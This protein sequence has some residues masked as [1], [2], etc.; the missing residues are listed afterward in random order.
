L[1]E[2]VNVYRV[3]NSPLMITMGEKIMKRHNYI[4]SFRRWVDKN[5]FDKL[6][7][8][9]KIFGVDL[10]KVIKMIE[11]SEK[12]S[13]PDGGCVIEGKAIKTLTEVELIR[14]PFI[15]TALEY[16]SNN[17]VDG[18]DELVECRP[19]ILL[20]TDFEGKIEMRGIWR[21]KNGY[22]AITPRIQ[23]SADGITKVAESGKDWSSDVIFL[24]DPE[25]PIYSPLICD[26][27]PTLE[28]D[29]LEIF[30][31]SM[32]RDL[33]EEWGVVFRLMAALSCSNVHIEKLPIPRIRERLKGAL[34]Y[35]SYNYL[36]IGNKNSNSESERNCR[37]SRSP[38]E[39]LR[40]GHIRRL[41]TGNKI[42]VNSTVVNP[43][44]GGKIIK[45]YVAC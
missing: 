28:S 10:G 11:L 37:F 42:W 3:T 40:R 33:E 38:R 12:F 9:Y 26:S 44:V 31:K 1:D 25:K 8:Y 17:E 4:R 7:G 15:A 24:S 19:R 27:K 35:D 39:H 29:K 2:V 5:G 43:G 30:T 45:E 36:V 41:S 20:V 16:Y 6:S 18:Q 13:L 32:R 23:L 14:M 22:W 34:A 21:Y